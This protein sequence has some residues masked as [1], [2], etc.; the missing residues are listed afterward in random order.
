MPKKAAKPQ[1]N[2][3]IPQ[4]PLQM[5]K[6][7]GKVSE[8]DFQEHVWGRKALRKKKVQR[9]LKIIAGSAVVLAVLAAGFLVTDTLL[10]ISEM[11]QEA[12][13]TTQPPAVTTAPPNNIPP[14]LAETPLRSFYVPLRMLDRNEDSPK[15]VEQAGRLGTTAAVI[16]FKDSGGMLSYRSNLMQQARINASQ[17]ARYRTDWTVKDL[18][19]KGGQRIIAVVHCFDD[20]LAAGAMPEA[21][22]I[23]R[24]TD[25]TPWTDGQGRRWLNPYSSQATEYLLALIREIISFGADDILLCGVSFP[26]GSLQG[27]V[28][29][30]QTEDTPESRNAVLR[31][32]IAQAKQAAGEAGVYVMISGQAAIDGAE[33]LG[34]DLWDCAADA[35]AVDT[36][37]T[38]WAQDDSY[39]GTR[40]VVPVVESPEAAQGARDYIVLEDEAQ[41]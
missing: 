2:K 30:G 32:F 8:E 11:P 1:K 37:G 14:P 28:L 39:W 41:G 40:P 29:P 4:T 22:M 38:P 36:R 16:T 12:P 13:A 23:R 17:K 3:E 9:V 26:E 10:R 25:S 34:G 21:A 27:A 7:L 35:I 31:D 24:D 33:N 19:N 5:Q 15:L 6:P 18:K 20:P